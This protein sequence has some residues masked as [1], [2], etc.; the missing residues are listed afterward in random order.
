LHCEW[1]SAWLVMRAVGMARPKGEARAEIWNHRGAAADRLE[2]AGRET[3]LTHGARRSQRARRTRAV[4]VR[5]RLSHGGLRTPG[6]RRHG[7]LQT[8]GPGSRGPRS[9]GGRS[10]LGGPRTRNGLPSRDGRHRTGLGG[11]AIRGVG[12]D[13]ARPVVQSGQGRVR[14]TGRPVRVERSDPMIWRSRRTMPTRVS[15]I[16]RL[17]PSYVV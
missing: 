16:L 9:R 5:V 12:M 3:R 10:T 2:P 6:R 15:W 8:G 14:R 4:R 7:D 11:R 1:R 13:R 17:V